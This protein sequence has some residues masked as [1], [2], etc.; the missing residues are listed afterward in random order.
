MPNDEIETRYCRYVDEVLNRHRLDV[1]GSYL[2]TDV[3]SRAHASTTGRDGARALIESLVSA[4]PDFHVTVDTL[5]TVEGGLVARLTATGTHLGMFLGVP[6]TGRSFCVCAFGA[7][8]VRDGQC[9]E[10]WLQLDLAE[11][12][13]QLGGTLTPAARLDRTCPR[14]GQGRSSPS[15]S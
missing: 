12:V 1:V 2:A 7:W 9:A 5:A 11:L 14:P 4:F 8:Q 13:Q 6:P 3:I 10:Q 15:A